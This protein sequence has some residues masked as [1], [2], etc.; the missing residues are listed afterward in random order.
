MVARWWRP[1]PNTYTRIF[2]EHTP[3][4][5]LFWQ[6]DYD[7]TAQIVEC[8]GWKLEVSDHCRLLKPGDIIKIPANTYHK[9]I[10]GTGSFVVEITNNESKSHT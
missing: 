3:E 5:D 6:K 4:S 7:R 8:T 2:R 10:K 9:I 1:D